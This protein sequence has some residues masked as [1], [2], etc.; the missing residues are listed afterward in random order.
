M[1]L[2]RLAEVD[3]GRNVE[4]HTG[5]I[6]QLVEPLGPNPKLLV[7]DVSLQYHGFKSIPTTWETGRISPWPFALK[8]K[9][10]GDFWLEQ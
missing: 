8:Q 10:F 1:F 5:P 6:N 4:D 7:A 9:R 2:I 3:L